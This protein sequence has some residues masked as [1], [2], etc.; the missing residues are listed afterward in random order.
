MKAE[1][2]ELFSLDFDISEF[3]PNDPC[4]FGVWLSAMIGPASE[5][6]SESFDILVCS[7]D[8]LKGTYPESEPVWGRHMLIVGRFDHRK[9]KT[10]IQQYVQGCSG[11]S[12]PEIGTQISRIGA[13]E[14]EDY[15]KR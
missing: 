4:Y 2:K 5:V 3:K 12:W 7:P 8:W 1:L 14:F 13:W 6:G 11:D 9:I 10:T 15:V